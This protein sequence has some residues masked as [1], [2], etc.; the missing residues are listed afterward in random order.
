MSENRVSPGTPSVP[1]HPL[2]AE[3][4]KTPAEHKSSVEW[5]DAFRELLE[6]VAGTGDKVLTMA[7]LAMAGQGNALVSACEEGRQRLVQELLGL[8]APPGAKDQYGYAPIH[9]AALGGFHDI[10]AILVA[11]NEAGK[12]ERRDKDGRTALHLASEAGHLSTVELLLGVGADPTIIPTVCV[13]SAFDVAAGNGRLDVLKAFGRFGAVASVGCA[14]A[15][16]ANSA[17]H[18]ACNGNQASSIELLMQEFGAEPNSL[19]NDGASGLHLAALCGQ[20]DAINSMLQHGADP[21]V[22]DSFWAFSSS[23][24]SGERMYRRRQSSLCRGEG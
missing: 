24:C 4:L 12:D 10:V 18:L 9:A 13:Y 15:G 5:C 22:L 17:L 3:I 7:V 19:D 21:L 20:C 16:T 14:P 2:Q 23:N 11:K 6:K 8:G 1:Q